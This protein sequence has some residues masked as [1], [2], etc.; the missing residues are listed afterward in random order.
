MFVLDTDHCIEILRGR[1]D[2]T[3]RISPATPLFVTAIGVGE[4]YYGAHRSDRAQHHLKQLATLLGGVIILPFDGRAA[5][6]YGRIKADLAARGELIGEPDLQI[7]SIA[8]RHGFV[9]ITH[10]Q[11]HFRRVPGLK[12][13]D[14]LT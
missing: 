13:D 6:I 7:A 10:N 1:L 14:W 9:L 3:E 11:E 2:I 8:L 4:L 5:R 12:L